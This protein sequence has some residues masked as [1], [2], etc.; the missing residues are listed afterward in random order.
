LHFHAQVFEGMEASV[1][2]IFMGASNIDT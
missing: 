2:S 1:L